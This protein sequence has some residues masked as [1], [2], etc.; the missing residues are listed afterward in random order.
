MVEDDGTVWSVNKV[1]QYDPVTLEV[2]GVPN[3]PITLEVVEKVIIPIPVRDESTTTI[4][5]TYLRSLKYFSLKSEYKK[6]VG[7]PPQKMTVDE[8]IM[9]ILDK[10]KA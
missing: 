5:E 2:M 1:I 4:R 6:V 7:A 8:L 3:D 10:E 9:G